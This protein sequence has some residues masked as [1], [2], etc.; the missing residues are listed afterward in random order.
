MGLRQI[1]K[2]ATARGA[3]LGA[4]AIDPDCDA[5]VERCKLILMSPASDFGRET[6]QKLRNERAALEAEIPDA[7]HERCLVIGM[8]LGIMKQLFDLITTRN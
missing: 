3:A 4:N 7:S 6:I 8:R 1:L 2:T 5:L